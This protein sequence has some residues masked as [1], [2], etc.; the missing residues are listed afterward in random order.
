[1]NLNTKFILYNLVV[2][3]SVIA[4]L[5]IC[6]VILVDKISL[7]HLKQRIVD[8]RETLIENLSGKEMSELL[9]TERSFT[10]YNILKE[11]YIILTQTRPFKLRDVN[12]QDFKIGEREIEGKIDEYLIL[13]DHFKFDNH[14][15]RL[16]IGETTAALR[17]TKEMVLYLTLFMLV[18]TGIITLILDYSFVSVLL[19]PFYKIIDRKLKNVND[20]QLF[21]YTRVKT[22]TNDFRH[23]DENIN[24]LMQ[25]LNL[26]FSNQKQFISNVSHELL[27][28]VSILKTRL[29]N[30]LGMENLPENAEDKIL[31]SLRTINRLK[32]IVNSLLLISKVENSQYQKT[33][34][35]NIAAEVLEVCKD[36][37][38][39]MDMRSIRLLNEMGQDFTFRA[40]A[41]LIHTLFLNIINNAIKYNKE[42]GSIRISDHRSETEYC[43]SVRDEGKGM[44]AEMIRKAFNRFEKFNSSL[45]DSYGLGL[46]IVN[47]IASF[48][49]IRI[50]ILSTEGE[51]TELLVYFPFRELKSGALQGL[52]MN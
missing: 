36:L 24:A 8:K 44:D 26:Q 27:T 42:G 23:L 12:L 30:M 15:Y 20:P 51:G 5:T 21:D 1:M 33:D 45:A 47:T 9:E 6:I 31:D 37:E 17:Q 10:D 25:K 29:E 19:S 46:A 4:F 48:H 52:S 7:S 38:D 43:V 40:N 32:S 11:E 49:N 13:T 35:V 14:Y 50:D 18:I 2:K 34:E 39:R 16:E 22:T 3:T 41:A 28:P